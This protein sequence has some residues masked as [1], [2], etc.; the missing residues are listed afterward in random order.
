MKRHTAISL[1]VCCL[2]LNLIIPGTVRGIE[3]GVADV[4]RR[5]ITSEEE[6]ISSAAVK[7][8]RHIAEARA[9]IHEKNVKHAM[10]ELRQSL[11][12]LGII[13]SSLPTEK[14]KDYIQVAKKHLSYEKTKEVIPDLIPIYASIDEIKDIVSVDK[15]GKHLSK[16]RENLEKGNREGAKKELQLAGESLVYSEIDLPLTYT[17]KHVIAARKFLAKNELEKA[18]RAL[19]SAEDSVRFLSVDI[20]SPVTQAKKSLWLAT[21]DYTAGKLAAAK[22]ELGQARRSLEKAVKT[23]NDKTRAEVNELLKD[24]KTAEAGVEKSKE[25]IGS[26][27]RS[28]WERTKALSD[29]NAERVTADWQSLLV[30]SPV[31]ANIIDA[32]LHVAYAETYQITDGKPVKARSEIDKA[33]TFIEKALP[34]TDNMTEA[35]LITIKTYLKEMKT[36]VDRRDMAAKVLYENIKSEL[37]DLI[38]NLY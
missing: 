32:R 16:A 8:L 6:A 19:K 18:D 26:D 13:K 24:M 34:D 36:D 29:H 4:P 11:T 33:L 38:K 30:V 37:R 35:Q 7:A 22:R 28:L 17:E 14:V 21:K 1:A 25:R 20:Y 10:E 23:G 3:E 31:T 12:L 9:G 15:A 27:I 2:L 5:I